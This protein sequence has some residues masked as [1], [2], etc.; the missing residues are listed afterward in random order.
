M[1]TR[2]CPVC[3]T[4]AEPNKKKC[5]ECGF[6]DVGDVVLDLKDFDH[7]KIQPYLFTHGLSSL[8]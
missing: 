8:R 7:L 6:M 1:A 4:P 2:Y 3:S 5:Q